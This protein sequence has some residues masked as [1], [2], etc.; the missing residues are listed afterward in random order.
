MVNVLLAAAAA[1]LTEA[2]GVP[3]NWREAVFLGL[4]ASTAASAVSVH[5]KG[6]PGPRL[7]RALSINAGFWS[8]AAV[9]V[10]GSPPDL[11]KALPTMLVLLPTAWCVRRGWGIGAK[12]LASW[13]IAIA[14]LSAALPL[15]PTPGY[16]PDHME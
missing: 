3:A 4:W 11:A 13:L 10:A 5:L 6:G 8:G 7:A 15:V 16:Q 14:L 1:M 12:V 9:S 2:V